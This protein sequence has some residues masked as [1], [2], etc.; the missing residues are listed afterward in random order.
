[1]RK[2]TNKTLVWL[3]FS[4]IVLLTNSSAVMGNQLG[5]DVTMNALN[6]N[7]NI[8]FANV[9]A[10]IG[11]ATYSSVF[12]FGGH[13]G[14][15]LPVA[16][17]GAGFA[18]TTAWFIAY[19]N[20]TEFSTYLNRAP[21][22]VSGA[23][24]LSLTL[25]YP[26]STSAAAALGYAGSAAAS[27][28][29]VYGVTFN[30]ISF[31]T[32]GA[33]VVVWH[34]ETAPFASVAGHVE[35]A[36]SNGYASL[37]DTNTV[38]TSPVGWAGYGVRTIVNQKVGML[39]MGWVNPNGITQSGSVYTLSSSNIFGSVISPNTGFGLSRIKYSFP[40][41]ITPVTNGITPVTSNPLPHVTG[42]MQWDQ[43]HPITGY[44]L[45]SAA[46][47]QVDYTLGMD[48]AFPNVQNEMVVDQALLESQGI[49]DVTFNLEN[50][51]GANATDIGVHLPV[52]DY[53]PMLN[54]SDLKI[55][56]IRPEYDLD[57]T[58]TTTISIKTEVGGVVTST[59]TLVVVSGWYVN[60]G[61]SNLAHWNTGTTSLVLA[62]Q[63]VL[64]V[65]TKL[66]L[67][68]PQGLPQF[69]LDA[70]NAHLTLPVTDLSVVGDALPNILNDTFWN[71]FTTIYQQQ[72]IFN[73]D[74]GDF[75]LEERQFGTSSDNA[76]NV[77]F[78]SANVDVLTPGQTTSLNFRVT[79]I[80]TASSGLYDFALMK[81]RSEQGTNFPY[82]NISSS[83]QNYEDFMQ[84]LFELH[85]FDGRP[86]SFGFDTNIQ[87]GP[88]AAPMTYTHANYFSYGAFVSYANDQGFPFFGM[89]NGQNVQIADDES[90]VSATVSLDQQVYNPGDTKTIT[91]NL[92]VS[93]TEAS[94]VVVHLYQ[95]SLGRDWRFERVEKVGEINAG[96][97]AASV[98]PYSYTTQITA[99]SYLGYSPVFAVVEFDSD[100]GQGP[101]P[102]TDFFEMGV[103]SF[104]AG[105]EAHH[106]LLSTLTGSLLV[107][108]DATELNPSI[109]VPRVELTTSTDPVDTSSLYVGDQF[110]VTVTM[111]N[112]GEAETTAYYGQAYETAGLTLVDYTYTTGA[113]GV[114]DTFGDYGFIGVGSI[115][116][117]VGASA[118]V[119]MTFEVVGATT[120]PSPTVY[121]TILGESSL[122]DTVD[123]GVGI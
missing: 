18:E 109:A 7:P 6:S 40:Y 71:G 9:A 27:F 29:S 108:A 58:F 24:G 68:A 79:D 49:L 67:D 106:I 82:A 119:T 72:S 76:V 60:A 84:Y 4:M 95:A 88:L 78:L 37:F 46:N 63:T 59:D 35:T 14:S 96:N 120:L 73:V 66:L 62:S 93:G 98:T 53:F 107:D 51:G 39:G 31:T 121:F 52:G 92:R 102:V 41:P 80:P 50:I 118:T 104:E 42:V 103:T 57:E 85:S 114:D 25:T 100:A 45:G 22:P 83:T 91:T 81:L 69:L 30:L 55:W 2:F 110:T 44:S 87:F 90:L 5:L 116:L 36:T 86:L 77:W 21:A 32:S 8:E 10:G 122:G 17:D 105:G 111:T 94:N 28:E 47:Y 20:Q 97:L 75:T 19:I 16:V 48:V 61:T 3:S 123:T 65:T 1:M 26:E 117:G 23:D 54:N 43:R 33:K 15:A 64:T 99:D 74:L 113:V 13:D 12:V 101:E 70:I 115:N 38:T 11:T 112:V 89:S 34:T 56:S